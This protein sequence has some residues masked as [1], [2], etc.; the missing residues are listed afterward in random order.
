MMLQL[1]TLKNLSYSTT[2][3]RQN[4]GVQNRNDMA[5]VQTDIGEV[6]TNIGGVRNV[7]GEYG[8]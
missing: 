1:E 4:A 3:L 8:N 2:P 6:R 5:E 7:I